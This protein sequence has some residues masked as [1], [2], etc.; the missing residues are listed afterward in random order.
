[1]FA[2]KQATYSS[3][4]AGFL[5]YET[6]GIHETYFSQHIKNIGKKK[7]KE[8]YRKEDNTTF[9]ISIWYI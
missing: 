1:M 5:N 7:G 2:A 6:C 4:S 8:N 9:K 3:T